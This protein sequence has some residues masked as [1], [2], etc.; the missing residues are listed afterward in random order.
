MPIP[1]MM[2]A[3]GEEPGCWNPAKRQSSRNGVSG[4]SSMFIL[5]LARLSMIEFEEEYREASRGRHVV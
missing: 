2:L 5:S 1:A 4:S 3:E